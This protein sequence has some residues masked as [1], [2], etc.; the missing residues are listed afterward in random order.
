MASKTPKPQYVLDMT[1]YKRI[2]SA[3]VLELI[4]EYNALNDSSQLT[5]AELCNLET[6]LGNISTFCAGSSDVVWLLK[7]L[8][9]PMQHRLPVL[10]LFKSLV[11]HPGSAALFRKGGGG[12]LLGVACQTLKGA[13][14]NVPLLVVSLQLIANLL[15]LSIPKNQTLTHCSWILE[16]AMDAAANPARLVQVTYASMCQNF[17]IASTTAQGDLSRKIAH[18]LVGPI[19]ASLNLVCLLDNIHDEWAVGVCSKHL[20]SL[21]MLLLQNPAARA[22]LSLDFNFKHSPKLAK[23]DVDATHALAALQLDSSAIP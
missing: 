18:A 6:C 23:L 22:N 2:N 21:E 1:L 3:K 10:D 15:H 8:Q 16:S 7:M 13:G 4:K 17:A 19:C 20:K 9:W 11:L 5:A 14:G 12:N